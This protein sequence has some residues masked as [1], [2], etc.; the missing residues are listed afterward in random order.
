VKKNKKEKKK[1][2]SSIVHRRRDRVVVVIRR[3]RFFSKSIIQIRKWRDDD[4]VDGKEFGWQTPT[5]A[6]AAAATTSSYKIM[7]T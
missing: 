1:R 2:S 5:L 6:T 4:E 7:I 3:L